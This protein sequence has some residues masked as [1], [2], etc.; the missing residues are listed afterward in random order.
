MLPKFLLIPSPIN[1][2]IKPGF[3][4][5]FLK[6]TY[7]NFLIYQGYVG[8]D[9]QGSLAKECQQKTDVSDVSI[10]EVGPDVVVTF[11]KVFLKK[12]IITKI[13]LA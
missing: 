7:D 3:A 10:L 11:Y 9:Q 6:I 4:S 13:F 8:K 2:P 5:S 1:S 12:R